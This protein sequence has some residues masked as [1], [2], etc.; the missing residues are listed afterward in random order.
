MNPIS[1]TRSEKWLRSQ[2]PDAI[3]GGRGK[4]QSCPL[5][6]ELYDAG[7]RHVKIDIDSYAVAYP[8]PDWAKDFVNTLDTAG[9]SVYVTAAE[10]AAIMKDVRKRLHR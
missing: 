10:A 9:D 1:R 3:V 4:G 7:L 6:S 5:A 8:L 2:K